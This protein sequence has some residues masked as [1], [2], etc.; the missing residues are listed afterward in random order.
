MHSP[1]F[2]DTISISV[3][4]KRI[5]GRLGYRRGVT[6]IPSRQQEAVEQYIEDAGSLIHLQGTALRLPIK[7]ND[8]A[9]ITLSNDLIFESRQLAAFLKHCQEV[10]LMGAT[11]GNDIMRAIEKDAASDN[12]KRSVVFDAA[13]SEMADASLDWIMSYFKQNLRRENKTLMQKRYS[14]GY[15]DFLLENQKTIHRLLELDRIG[16]K[17]T[18]SCILVP[19]KSVT[20]I[21]GVKWLI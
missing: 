12:L 21:A 16:V 5:Y 19:E 4:H 2:F 17:I 13:A 6:R 9:R 10:I 7:E 15:G 11:A 18:A 14:A 20:A 3:P 8:T 1:I